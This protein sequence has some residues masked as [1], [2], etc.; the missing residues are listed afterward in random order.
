[1]ISEF[2]KRID[3]ARTESDM[4]AIRKDAAEKRPQMT[5]IEWS[6]IS[7]K[8]QRKSVKMVNPKRVTS[9]F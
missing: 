1:M 7:S 2:S 3:G 8:I 5:E 4:L 9:N 6:A